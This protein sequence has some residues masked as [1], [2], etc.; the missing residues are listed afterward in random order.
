M[1]H[2]GDVALALSHSQGLLGGFFQT[3]A[4]LWL[5]GALLLALA[6]LLR[7][8]SVRLLNDLDKRL[9]RYEREALRMDADVQRMLTELPLH[10]YR[11]EDA[12]REIAQVDER[13]AR[14]VEQV[15]HTL[16]D[17][18]GDTRRRMEA[19]ER[20]RED[21]VR[22]YQMRDDAIREYT[23]INAKLDRLYEVIIEV[24]DHGQ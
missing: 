2:E 13:Y 20:S 10:Y 7:W 15:I 4:M 6:L 24:K 9:A 23:A 12:L 11:R 14:A 21:D 19:I 18:L 16:R 17:E 5:I 22:R 8:F 1:N 3:S